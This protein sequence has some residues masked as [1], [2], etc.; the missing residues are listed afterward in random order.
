MSEYLPDDTEQ[1]LRRYLQR[2]HRADPAPGQTWQ[3]VAARL[4]TPKGQPTMN[5]TSQEIQ[6]SSIPSLALTERQRMQRGANPPRR[7]F[8]ASAAG[9]AA[10]IIMALLARAVFTR[11]PAHGTSSYH[12]VQTMVM[13]G[14]RGVSM[15]SADDGWAVGSAYTLRVGMGNKTPPKVPLLFNYNGSA[16]QAVAVPDGLDGADLNVVAM[17]NAQDGWAGGGYFE[18]PEK[19]GGYSDAPADKLGVL[20]HYDGGTWRSITVPQTLNLTIA[21]LVYDSAGDVWAMA[22]SANYDGRFAILHEHAGTWT[23]AHAGTYGGYIESSSLGMLSANEG[24]ATISYLTG[25]VTQGG[26]LKTTW[27]HLQNDEWTAA[28][29]TTNSVFESMDII[30]PTDGWATQSHINADGSSTPELLHYSKGTW[31]SVAHPTTED[32]ATI[33]GIVS[34]FDSTY[35]WFMGKMGTGDTATYKYYI[36][37]GSTWKNAHITGNGYYA[38]ASFSSPGDGWFVGQ[39]ATNESLADSGTVSYGFAFAHYH[40]GTWTESV[41]SKTGK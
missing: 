29:T 21:H 27:L 32:G 31:Q 33:N 8:L 17:R 6:E 24:W 10:V 3:G 11:G 39:G 13:S 38:A 4:A 20:L 40:N 14:L 25:N 22:T 35:G 28:T 19:Y 9:L 15:V 12:A 23:V 34:L 16:W 18:D 37:D 36:F 2:Q 26:P 41:P 5:E 30:S 1:Q 7:G